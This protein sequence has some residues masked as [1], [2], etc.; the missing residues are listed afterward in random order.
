MSEIRWLCLDCGKNTLHTDDYYMLR[1]KLWRE[2]VPREQRHG[3]LCLSCIESRLGRPL[4]PGDFLKDNPNIEESDP[5]EQPMN[6]SDYGIIDTLSA[7]DM[8]E[9]D[10]GLI[11]G[12]TA[13]KSH[14]VSSLIAKFI[15]NSPTAIP[16]LPDYFYLLRI[17]QMV[18]VG[19]LRVDNDVGLLMRSTVRL[20]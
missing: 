10:H 20:A 17:E 6:L 7:Q 1:N 3:M 12:V 8:S 11:D 5:A 13:D 15:E 18:D 9:I 14:K 4:C 2:I 19:D 16:G